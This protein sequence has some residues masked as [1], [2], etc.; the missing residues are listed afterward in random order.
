MID[1]SGNP[2]LM[3]FGISSITR[4]D[5]SVNASTPNGSG[6]TRWQAPELL[7]LSTKA[8]YRDK[9]KSVRPTNKSD[10]YSLAMVMIEVKISCLAKNSVS[11]PSG[12]LQIFTGKHPFALHTEQQV[13]LLLARDSRPNKPVHVQFSPKMWS[14]T[15]KCWD[16]DPKKRPDIP[17]VLKK[18]ESGDGAFSFIPKAVDSYSRGMQ[19]R[20]GT[21]YFQLL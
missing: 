20:S 19:E 10:V 16:K 11:Q 21:D 9:V 8:N 18:L 2:R 13:I 6:S 5:F 14:L 1:A 3:D 12:N 15:K 7:P 4:N 17:E